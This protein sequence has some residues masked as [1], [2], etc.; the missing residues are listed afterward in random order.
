MSSLVFLRRWRT[1]VL[2]WVEGDGVRVQV[3]GAAAPLRFWK[4]GEK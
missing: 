3:P 2:G 4:M 1:E